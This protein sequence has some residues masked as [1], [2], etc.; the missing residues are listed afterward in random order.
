M[1]DYG[2]VSLLVLQLAACI[3]TVVAWQGM[4][5]EADSLRSAHL[6]G[7]THYTGLDQRVRVSEGAV[8]TFDTRLSSME[9]DIGKATRAA[10][11]AQE[12]TQGFKGELKSL[13]ASI[14]ANK[15]WSREEEAG[16]MTDPPP[17]DSLYVPEPP[18][19][20][21]NGTFGVK[22]V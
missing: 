13:R 14:A 19:L 17:P 8:N 18:P 4:R 1:I 7:K 11:H 9:S 5:K 22:A 21:K 15:R 10:Q 2:I 12:E 6:E 16:G 3:G 20:A